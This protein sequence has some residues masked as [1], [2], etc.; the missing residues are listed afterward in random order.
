MYGFQEEINKKYGNTSV[1]KMFN[2]T[3]DYLP[4][5]ALIDSK[6]FL[7]FRLNLLCPWR[8]IS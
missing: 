2:D 5:G 8:I 7:I 4:L 1:W 3:F 6:S